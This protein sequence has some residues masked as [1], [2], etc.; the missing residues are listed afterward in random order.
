ME[1]SFSIGKF[2]LVSFFHPSFS[3]HHT[4]THRQDAS[5]TWRRVQQVLFIPTEGQ[6]ISLSDKQTIGQTDRQTDPYLCSLSSF[7]SDFGQTDGQTSQ[8]ARWI[9]LF[10]CL[11]FVSSL[12]RTVDVTVP[13]EDF[14][15]NPPTHPR[16]IHTRDATSRSTVR[17]CQHCAVQCDKSRCSWWHTTTT[18]KRL[19]SLLLVA[20]LSL[21]LCVCSAVQC[22]PAITTTTT[23]TTTT[24]SNPPPVPLSAPW[25]S[26]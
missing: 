16:G 11:F 17:V 1:C 14:S 21:S 7:G 26:T 10:F 25:N 23:T 13:C 20:P 22:N 5:T 15:A 4:S 6:K 18:T 8:N 24:S 2:C 9:P 3:P 12:S 19:S